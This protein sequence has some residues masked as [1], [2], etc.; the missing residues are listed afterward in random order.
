MPPRPKVRSQPSETTLHTHSGEQQPSHGR[1]NVWDYLGPG[2]ENKV[3]DP[4]TIVMADSAQ[5]FELSAAAEPDTISE[6]LNLDLRVPPDAHLSPNVR[7]QTEGHRPDL[8]KPE[9]HGP[10]IELIAIEKFNAQ[11]HQ[12]LELAESN[13][14]DNGKAII[15]RP[16]LLE[17]FRTQIDVAFEKHEY[18]DTG[19]KDLQL[20]HGV[21]RSNSGASAASLCEESVILSQEDPAARDVVKA[22]SIEGAKSM[23]NNVIETTGDAMPTVRRTLSIHSDVDL[24][25]AS[26]RNMPISEHSRPLSQSSVKHETLETKNPTALDDEMEAEIEGLSVL[27]QQLSAKHVDAKIADDSTSSAPITKSHVSKQS[28]SA[29]IQTE[30]QIDERKSIAASSEICLSPQIMLTPSHGDAGI[31][32]TDPT[33]P[34]AKAIQS[35]V[36]PPLVSP[37]PPT[38]TT[39]IPAIPVSAPPPSEIG[40]KIAGVET[41]TA[42]SERD[43]SLFEESS[44]I[45]S[46][47]QSIDPTISSLQQSTSNTTATSISIDGAALAREQAQLDLRRLQSELTAAKNRGDSQAFQDSVQK[48]IEVIRRTYLVST[49]PETKKSSSLRERASF[50][51]FSSLT[52]SSN[53]SALCDAAAGGNLTSVKALVNARVNIDTRGK[54]FMTPLML[55]AINGHT[56]C[57]SILRQHGADEFAVDAKGRTVLHL[58]VASNRA[59]VVRWLLNS[60]PP[61]RPQTLKHRASILSKATESLMTRSPKNLRE[62][63]DAEGSKPIHISLETDR[64]GIL[65]ILLAAGVDIESKN[66]WSRTPLHQAIISGRRDSFDVLLRNGANINALDAKA[67]SPLHWAAKIGHVDMIQSLL[68]KG[69][70]RHEFDN[71]GNQPIHE[72]AWVGK[73]PCIEV[74]LTERKDLEVPTKSGESLLHIACLTKNSELMT[75]LL[76]CNIEVN[77]WAVPQPMLLNALSKFKVPLSSLTPLHYACCK[78]DLEIAMHLIDH[79]AWINAAT[80]EGVT[81]LMMAAESEDT[82]TINL[83]LSRGAKVNAS[84]P[85]TLLTALHISSRRG[86]LES[87]QQLCRA[88]ANRHARAHAGGSSYG[89]TPFEET[90]AKCA[91]TTKKFA[92]E[93]YYR[94]IRQNELM[95]ARIRPLGEQRHSSDT[96]GRAYGTG[97][98]LDIRPTQPISY[99]PWG[100]HNVV[101]IQQGQYGYQQQSPATYPV[102]MQPMQ[103]QMPSQ[104]YDPD[105]ANHVESPPPYQPG[106]NVSTRLA[107]QAAVHR[108]SD[109]AGT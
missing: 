75:Y 67:M 27:D 13:L 14:D 21:H 86:D 80:P 104:W 96:V 109:N 99:A 25:E 33:P 3:R 10:S 26:V 4:S 63:S 47:E 64:G 94:T 105:P 6:E 41:S 79:E 65:E 45:S 31:P 85:G 1:I 48:S 20:S 91:N 58:A 56:E 78:G 22:S 53:G 15:E 40:T 108:P 106:P 49:S 8:V 30:D 57:M 71:D 17:G 60:Y 35:P 2:E 103:M 42:S 90:T 9:I 11:S 16:T 107:A 73:V 59:A 69:A 12:D 28:G 93:N 74:V 29:E 100:Q 19:L 88:G 55:A 7:H 97:P 82:N 5:V 24:Y 52:G 61:P 83:L 84:M 81:A 95:N 51:R 44:T 101:P 38:L 92:V 39:S 34:I 18:S 32:T 87:V 23:H 68:V 46:S 62:T 54:A 72:A 37:T 76:N 89:R 66:N 70:D 36:S 98:S 102:Y 50:R 77:P 43:S